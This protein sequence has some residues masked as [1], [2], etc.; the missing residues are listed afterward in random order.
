M[1]NLHQAHNAVSLSIIE[2]G[3]QADHSWKEKAGGKA[4]FQF[5]CN[6]DRRNGMDTEMI[7]PVTK[8]LWDSSLLLAA[9]SWP[10]LFLRH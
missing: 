1:L 8:D 7:T 3:D 4:S 6:G 9:C 2:E 10:R 5:C